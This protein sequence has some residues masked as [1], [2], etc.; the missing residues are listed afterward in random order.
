MCPIKRYWRVLPLL[1]V[2][3]L[4][5]FVVLLVLKPAKI[6]YSV[7]PTEVLTYIIDKASEILPDKVAAIVQNADPDYQLVDVRNPS[8][9][10]LGM[11]GT[12]I[13]IPSYELLA[14]KNRK[15][16]DQCSKDS[17]TLILYGDTQQEANVAWMLLHQVG[18]HNLK[19]MSGGYP[20]FIG[21]AGTDNMK[22]PCPA[23]EKAT[24]DVSIVS[25]SMSPRIGTPAGTNQ[26][27]NVMPQ[28][29]KKKSG[30]GGGC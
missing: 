10:G 20:C 26:R 24:F 5:A 1:A 27:E 30:S 8:R 11:I 29:R 3:L 22:S 6:K 4:L 18:Y 12:A 23:G 28:K 25:R 19:V 17:L 16:F 14:K 7:T 9:F 2:A 21:N 15:W 13:N